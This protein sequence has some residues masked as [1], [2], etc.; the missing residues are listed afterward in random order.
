MRKAVF[1][2]D[3]VSE[4]SVNGAGNF[5]GNYV[6][7]GIF[8]PIRFIK[9]YALSFMTSVLAA[10]IAMMQRIGSFDPPVNRFNQPQ[11]LRIDQTL[12]L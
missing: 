6:L 2:P 5:G 11:Q 12:L 10:A 4:K 7:L 1:W 3:T 9:F 8:N